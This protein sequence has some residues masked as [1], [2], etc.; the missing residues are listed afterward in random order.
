MVPQ[1]DS[2]LHKRAKWGP[3]LESKTAN[4]QGVLKIVPTTKVNQPET[5]PPT[6]EAT[7]G[8]PQSQVNLSW[9]SGLVFDLTPKLLECKRDTAQTAAKSP[10]HQSTP[11]IRGKLKTENSFLLSRGAGA[12]HSGDAAWM[13]CRVW[14]I[15]GWSLHRNGWCFYG[16][17]S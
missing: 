17:G 10:N 14:A 7:Q 8:S 5:A 9:W 15:D 2:A 4:R 6:N 11:P 1:K 13:N 12:R 16:L 3:P